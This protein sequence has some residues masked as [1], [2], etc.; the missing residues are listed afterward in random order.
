M[1]MGTKEMRLRKYEAFGRNL[2][3]RVEDKIIEESCDEKLLGIVIN[4]NLSWYTHLYGNGLSG[5]EKID[6]LL[7]QLSKRTGMLKKVAPLMKRS[8]LKSV[9]DGGFNAKL[10]YGIQL[11]CNTWGISPMDDTNRR[12]TAFGK[13][14]LRRLQVLQNITL[15]LQTKL[16]K[17]TPTEQLLQASNALS[18][19]QLGALH[20][21]TMTHKILNS[22]KPTYLS[23]Q[24]KWRRPDGEG[25][26]PGRQSS[27]IKV[28]N[29]ELT[30]SR[31]GLVH[32]SSKL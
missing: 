32:R 17:Y 1:V 5:A 31:S 8:Q 12:Y 6:G 23:D 3:V 18:V 30:L 13:D 7:P 16:N 28:R 22:Q 2:R 25:A 4:N 27:K 21:I 14:D 24:M 29:S 9:I 10:I 19:H 26:F 15:R 11:F 20:T